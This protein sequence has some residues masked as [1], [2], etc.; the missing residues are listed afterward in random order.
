MVAAWS[1]REAHMLK[2]RLRD[3]CENLYILAHSSHGPREFHPSLNHD[4]IW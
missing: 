2:T 4:T 3:L 1:G